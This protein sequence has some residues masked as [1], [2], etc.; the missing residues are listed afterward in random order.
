MARLFESGVTLRR[1]RLALLAL[2]SLFTV[3]GVTIAHS[4]RPIK[5]TKYGAIP[6]SP[7]PSVA[8]FSFT[9]QQ[10]R[11]VDKHSLRGQVWIADFIYTTCTSACPLITSRFVA[12]QRRLPDER[13]R[14]VSFSVD[15]E[16]DTETALAA[17][18]AL[19][20]PTEARWR[21]LRSNSSGLAPLFAG[22]QLTLNRAQGE[23][24][25][26]SRL[27]LVNAEGTLLASFDSADDAAL[28]QLVKQARELLGAPASNETT[29][30]VS[31]SGAALYT[32]LGCA[33]CHANA[34]LAPPLSGLAGS[35]VML[36]HAGT[37]LADDTYLAE[38]IAFPTAKQVAGYPNSMPNYGSLL[39]PQQLQSLVTYVRSF[40]PE[41]AGPGPSAQTDP[42]CGMA[43]RVTPQ[44]PSAEYHGVTRHFC[45]PA[46]AL[47]F[48]SDPARYLMGTAAASP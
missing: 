47:R 29:S 9:D 35:H 41:L 8:A 30:A 11:L 22:L 5:S 1:A 48:K 13:L 31:G 19:W 23:L 33:G 37:V 24:M 2:G 25:H 10:G 20:A 16:R 43:V 44:T 34:Q 27:F 32:S 42:V 14:F 7:A 39:S 6:G 15:P 36:E 38:S 46:C 28:D 26:T 45:S 3:A 18:A 40:E 4:S 21:L 12:L 17:Y